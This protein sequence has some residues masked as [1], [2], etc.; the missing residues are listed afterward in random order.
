MANE[1]KVCPIRMACGNTDCD[2]LCE[3]RECMWY[4]ADRET[5]AITIL[6]EKALERRANDEKAD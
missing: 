4:V 3:V 2:A 5:C 6:A 1:L